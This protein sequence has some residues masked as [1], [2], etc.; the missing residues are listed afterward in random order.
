MSFTVE[1]ILEDVSL[2]LV[3]NIVNTTLGTSITSGSQ[4]VSPGSMIGIY[5]GA[6]LIIGFGGTQEIVTVVTVT[7][8]TFTA[9]FANSHV[10]T[11]AVVGATFSSG[12]TDHPMWTQAEM[13]TALQNVQNDFLLRVRP[14]YEIA[15]QGFTVGNRFYSQPMVAIRLE[16]IAYQ[17]TDLY[18]TTQSDLDL[19]NYTWMGDNDIPKQWFRD[20]IDTAKFGLYPLPTVNDNLKLLYSKRGLTN[21]TLL[22]ILLIPDVFA[23]AIKYGVLAMAWDKDGEARDPLRA[24]YA[25]K[26]FDFIV[27]LAQKF[28]EGVGVQMQ[29][30]KQQEAFSP[31]AIPAGA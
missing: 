29:K 20:Q 25:Q 28:L 1:Q 5:V 8:T 24:S 21:L 13:I 30:Q 18:E 9:T 31:M 27:M 19:D 23:Y 4:T 2:A 16:R 15:P 6:M 14:V 10:S 7:A 26:K 17:G 12:Q 3:E 11:D 22:S